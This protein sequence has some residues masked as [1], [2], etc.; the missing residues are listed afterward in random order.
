MLLLLCI[1][2]L[3]QYVLLTVLYYLS[4]AAQIFIP[5]FLY[6]GWKRWRASPPGTSLQS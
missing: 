1:D 3:R 5:D 4:T 6:R 2:L